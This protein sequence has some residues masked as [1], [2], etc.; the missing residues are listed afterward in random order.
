MTIVYN[1]SLILHLI[2]FTSRTSLVIIV[3]LNLFDCKFKE[4]L[5]QFEF[6]KSL[7]FVERSSSSE[8]FVRSIV[9]SVFPLFVDVVPSQCETSN[10]RFDSPR[11]FI[12]W[13]SLT[14]SSTFVLVFLVYFPDFFR[15]F[16]KF[17]NQK[18]NDFPDDLTF[19]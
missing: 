4:Y 7:E 19:F 8:S 18:L 2:F 9:C 5:V 14:N 1:Y 17:F 10:L 15:D 13:I 3:L 6:R 12:L 16:R 11:F